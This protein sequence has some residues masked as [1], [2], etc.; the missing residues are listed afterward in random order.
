MR[1]I[2][3]VLAVLLLTAC[4]AAPEDEPPARPPVVAT[5]VWD[6]ATI[7]SLHDLVAS[8]EENHGGVVGIAVAGPDAV[9][10][11][12]SNEAQF[13]WSTIKVP[14]AVAA[15][16]E[17]ADLANMLA[18]AAMTYSDNDA[19]WQLW[20][21]L[22]EGAVDNVFKK[23]GVA[24]K[25][26][27]REPLGEVELTP[28][29][30]AALASRLP[31]MDNAQPVLKL[32]AKVVDE[33][34]YGLGRIDEAKFK[35]G[36]G[37]DEDGNYLVRQMGLIPHPTGGEIAVSLIVQPDSGSYE[38]AQEM[39]DEIAETLE[40]LSANLPKVVCGYRR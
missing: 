14:I 29:Q 6:E 38:E 20:S 7:A 1:K 2:L 18:P 35:G 3:S 37:D 9:R 22:S 25:T 36:W 10:V 13:A 32:M 8:L 12:G 40:E 16:E 17:N 21:G 15:F 31:C 27:V 30:E 28:S 39:A 19:A 4:A 11:W 23:A 33:Q 5:S 34:S 24:M 26:K